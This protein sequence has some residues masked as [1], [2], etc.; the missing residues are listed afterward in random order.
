MAHRHCRFQ[1]FRVFSFG[2]K[3]RYAG[4]PP[5]TGPL[6][7]RVFADL[8]GSEKRTSKALHMAKRNGTAVIAHRR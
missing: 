5:R 6:N 1:G 3:A 2:T 8:D 4:P 7:R